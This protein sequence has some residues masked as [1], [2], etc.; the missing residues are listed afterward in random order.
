MASVSYECCSLHHC[1]F[2]PH[3]TPEIHHPSPLF[4]QIELTITLHLRFI[5][6]H[7]T[8]GRITNS[9]S[10]SISQET[11]RFDLQVLRIP[12]QLHQILAPALTRLGI[13]PTSTRANN[14][15]QEI[16]ELGNTIGNTTSNCGP[17][18][19]PLCAEIWGTVLI[20]IWNQGVPIRFGFSEPALEI[21]DGKYG[22][23]PAQ[24]SMKLKKVKV[25]DGDDDCAICLEELNIESYASQMPCSH[26]FHSNCIGKWLKKKKKNC[27]ICRFEMEA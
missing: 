5:H 17:I 7:C 3:A 11:L 25:E 24:E 16:L 15:I 6:L 19:L 18:V 2:Q 12:N 14:V 4:V 9:I 23:I 8:T 1:V 20:H 22:M 26:I 10:D 27:P 13:I 21:E